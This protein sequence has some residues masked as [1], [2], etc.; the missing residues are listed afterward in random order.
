[1]PMQCKLFLYWFVCKKKYYTVQF[2]KNIF[3]LRLGGSED[4]K[5]KDMETCK[6]IGRLIER[7]LIDR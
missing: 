6:Y 2:L 3:H 1:M 7:W 4:A 5:A